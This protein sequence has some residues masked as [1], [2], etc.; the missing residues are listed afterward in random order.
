MNKT[1]LTHLKTGAQKKT[2][3]GPEG[4]NT[5]SENSVWVIFSFLFDVNSN[6]NN[7]LGMG[8]SCIH[9]LTK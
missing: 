5:D 6:V 7:T 2:V 9:L 3:F 4:G 1:H 8:D